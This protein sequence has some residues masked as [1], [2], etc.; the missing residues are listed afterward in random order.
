M[1]ERDI[2]KQI[3]DYCRFRGIY[4][5]NN[6]NTGLYTNGRYIPAVMKGIPDILG[7]LGKTWGKLCGKFVC[8]EVKRE[9]NT[10]TPHQEYFVKEASENGC[11]SFV[12]YSVDDVEREL[13]K[14][15]N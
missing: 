3:L 12:A 7:Y 6:R 5:W 10:A 8:I 2:K 4:C 1:L 9:G 13:N 11:I 15:T 14:W